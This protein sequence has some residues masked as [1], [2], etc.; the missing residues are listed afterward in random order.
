MNK[1]ILAAAIAA[2]VAAPTAVLANDVTAYGVAHISVDYRNEDD[3]SFR[4]QSFDPTT[5]GYVPVEVN[6]AWLRNGLVPGDASDGFDMAS[7]ASRIGFKG[8]EDLANGLKAIW[9]MEFQVDM[10][11]RGGSCLSGVSVYPW[12]SVGSPTLNQGN[13]SGV[14]PECGTAIKREGQTE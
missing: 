9:K 12:G 14:C 10:A 6:P 5:G 11:D 3:S 8:T 4:F 1:K 7:R 2:A 13:V